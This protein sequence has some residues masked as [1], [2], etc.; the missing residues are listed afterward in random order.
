MLVV[1]GVGAVDEPVPPLA[2]VYQSRLVPV[3][4]SGV[5]V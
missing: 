4:V 2:V 3:A 1:N 5:A